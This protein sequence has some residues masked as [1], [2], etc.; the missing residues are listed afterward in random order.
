MAPS[1]FRRR[2]AGGLLAVG[3]TFGGVAVAPPAVAQ[4]AAA[5][6]VVDASASVATAAPADATLRHGSRG[7]GNVNSIVCSTL[8]RIVARFSS[9]R[10]VAQI[11]NSLRASFGCVSPG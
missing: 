3:L 8:N 9:F 2:M 1:P 6:S 11:L 10:F 5:V 7:R 4:P